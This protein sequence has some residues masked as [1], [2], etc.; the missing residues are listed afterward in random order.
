MSR[1]RYVDPHRRR[2]P[3]FRAY[4]RVTGT[5]RL[6]IWFSRKVLWKLDPVLLR[7][8]GGRLSLA[9]AIPSGLLETIGARTGE[10]RRHAVIYFHDGDVITIVASKFGD[11]EHPAWF[12]N[13]VAHPEVVFAGQPYRARVVDDESELARL[14]PLAEAFFPPYA[15]YRRRAAGT[16][17]TIPILQLTPP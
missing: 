5:T 1:L 10:V 4:V 6:A 9:P 2:G 14:W 15:V 17:R 8:T 3:V 16:G 12:H 13:A 11:P 7:L